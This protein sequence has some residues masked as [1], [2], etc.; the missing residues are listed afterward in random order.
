[1]DAAGQSSHTA[2]RQVGVHRVHF[3]ELH[4]QSWF[5]G[6]LRNDVTDTLQFGLNLSKAYAPIAPLLQ[7]ALDSTGSPSIVDLCSGGGGP[8]LDLAPRLRW[9][10]GDAHVS[11]TDKYPNPGAFESAQAHSKIPIRFYRG[12]VDAR[13]VPAE[14]DGF[15]TLFTSFHHFPFEEA[16]AIVQNAVDAGKGI[17]IFEITRRS[18]ST[19][20]MMVFWS[21]APLVFTLFVKPFR[22]SRLFYTY[23]IPVIPFVLLFDGAVSCLRTYR[24]AELRGMVETLDANGY[25]WDAGELR[26]GLLRPP[27][28]YLIGYPMRDPAGA[29]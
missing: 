29:G 5:P 15:R 27:V 1:M 9:K 14:L 21:L 26:D 11:L 18:P 12:P 6:F 23:V 24:P 25:R 20:L 4:E 10:G 3:I 7:G 28:T 2:P 17:G 19:L 13:N 8:W 16:R 22:W